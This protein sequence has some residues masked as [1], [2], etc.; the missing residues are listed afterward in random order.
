MVEWSFLCHFPHIQATPDE[1]I[2]GEYHS[3]LFKFTLSQFSPPEGLRWLNPNAHDLLA[4]G[5]LAV[6]RRGR[7]MIVPCSHYRAVGNVIW[8]Y[9]SAFFFLIETMKIYLLKLFLKII[10]KNVSKKLDFLKEKKK[11]F[12]LFLF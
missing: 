9:F 12:L 3:P 7:K 2:G 5:L 4:G 11:I 10:F 6:Q 1:D 8:L